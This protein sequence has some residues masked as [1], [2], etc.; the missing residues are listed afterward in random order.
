MLK[1]IMEEISPV[2]ERLMLLSSHFNM[3]PNEFSLRI[4]KNRSFVKG[5]TKEV[6]SDVLRHIYH[7]FKHVNITWIVTGEGDMIINDSED[8]NNDS[9]VF[10]LKEEN[11]LLKKENN[12]L[13][14]ENAKLQAK[15]DMY[16]SEKAG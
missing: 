10:H 14:R 1:I 5:I 3:S 2:K 8:I 11:R 16:D 7:T 12:N 6:G 4:G 13:I 15:L 9:L